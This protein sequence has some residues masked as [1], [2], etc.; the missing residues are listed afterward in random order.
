MTIV[1]VAVDEL[2]NT[3]ASNWIETPGPFEV[4]F[5][6]ADL[7]LHLDGGTG[8]VM[9]SFGDSHRSTAEGRAMKIV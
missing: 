2:Q 3:V 8:D 7:A 9:H 1:P 5:V 6:S 4:V